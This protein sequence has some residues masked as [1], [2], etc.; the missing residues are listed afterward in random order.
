MNSDIPIITKIE[1]VDGVR[2][3][4]M[5]TYPDPRGRLFKAFSSAN[6]EL[7]PISFNT[8]EHF[9]TESHKNVFR[10]M[11]FQ[12]NPHQVS[13]IVSIVQGSAIDFLFDMRENSATFRNLQIVNLDATIP[14][15][16]Y[17][18]TGVAHGY[19]ATSE[20]TIISYRMDGPFCAN[21]D[22]GFNGKLIANLLP[23]PFAKTIQSAR[24]TDL[25]QFEDYKYV[26]KCENK[27]E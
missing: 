16:I 17:I 23:I 18:P 1:N 9:F 19:L 21:C 13:K 8:N 25:I 22:G 20:K 14:S 24:D 3:W 2:V 15:S 4:S 26:S 27:F 5:P 11:H 7:L 12:G 6:L 10:G